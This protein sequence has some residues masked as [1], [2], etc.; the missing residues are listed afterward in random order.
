VQKGHAQTDKTVH[1]HIVLSQLLHWALVKEETKDQQNKFKFSELSNAIEN[2]R[3]NT[4]WETEIVVSLH[5]II[6]S[7]LTYINFTQSMLTDS[8]CVTSRF[9]TS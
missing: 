5:A 7:Q 1:V 2:K 8:V 3:L 4:S 9:I 6:F